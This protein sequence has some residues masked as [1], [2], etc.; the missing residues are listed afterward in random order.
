MVPLNQIKIIVLTILTT[1]SLYTAYITDKKWKK[2]LGI[3]S[4][5]LIIIF[6]YVDLN[7]GFIYYEFF[8]KFF[9]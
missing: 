4:F 2:I 8:V 3:I 6:V 7:Y 9:R 5:L 1:V